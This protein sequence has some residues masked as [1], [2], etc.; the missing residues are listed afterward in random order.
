MTNAR[1]N[2]VAGKWFDLLIAALGI[3][4]RICQ[5]SLGRSRFCGKKRGGAWAKKLKN[6]SIDQLCGKAVCF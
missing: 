5:M 1:K 3:S 6:V 4:R 2:C